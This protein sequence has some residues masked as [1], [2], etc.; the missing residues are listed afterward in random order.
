MND[1]MFD[2]ETFSRRPNAVICQIGACYFD[3]KTGEVFT[4]SELKINVNIGSYPKGFDIEGETL[5]WWFSQSREAFNSINKPPLVP[6]K[7]ALE[8]LNRFLS[9]AENIWSNLDFDPI[10]FQENLRLLKI[11]PR[12]SRRNFRD[13]RTVYKLAGVNLKHLDRE[14]TEHDALDDCKHQIKGLVLAL[15]ALGAVI[16]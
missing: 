12:S 15:E 9:G 10:I 7:M 5:N 14:G 1:V 4:H 6:A 11:E 8:Q 16:D 13:I 2:L 3:R